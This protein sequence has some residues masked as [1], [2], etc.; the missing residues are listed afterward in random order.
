MI[1]KSCSLPFLTALCYS[2][3]SHGHGSL[4]CYSWMG[5]EARENQANIFV[6]IGYVSKRVP[7]MRW[8]GM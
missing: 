4:L 5:M 1:M 2:A 3:G 6:T 8:K 7:F